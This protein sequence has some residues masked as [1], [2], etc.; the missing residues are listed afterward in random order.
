M[1]FGG[2]EAGPTLPVGGPF[3][4]S[5]A[6]GFTFT[7]SAGWAV[8]GMTKMRVMKRKRKRI[9][10]KAV[11][12]GLCILFVLLVDWKT[13]RLADEVDDDTSGYIKVGG[14]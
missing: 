3:S 1:Y 12:R 7:L 4:E 13:E 5:T 9:G 10:D 6:S 14:D 11:E 2:A 8:I